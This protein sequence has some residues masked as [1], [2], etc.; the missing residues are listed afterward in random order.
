MTCLQGLWIFLAW[1]VFR[2]RVIRA[3]H[4]RGWLS[5]IAGPIERYLANDAGEDGDDIMEHTSVPMNE[6]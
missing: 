6:H 4:K 1:V 3:M 5:C 2:K